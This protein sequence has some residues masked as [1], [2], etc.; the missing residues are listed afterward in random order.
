MRLLRRE[1]ARKLEVFLVQA[2]DANDCWQI[3]AKQIVRLQPRPDE[4]WST[5][6][7]ANHALEARRSPMLVSCVTHDDL[8]TSTQWL[9]SRW[10]LSLIGLSPDAG[11][12]RPRI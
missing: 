12:H 8:K 10:E 6:A 2:V 9:P 11:S 5:S 4:S 7:K 1:A 3:A